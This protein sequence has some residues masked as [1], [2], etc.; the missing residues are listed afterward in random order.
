MIM[1][2]MID[3]CIKINLFRVISII[4][5]NKTK[6]ITVVVLTII[7][8]KLTFKCVYFNC[9]LKMYN[10]SLNSVVTKVKLLTNIDAYR[11]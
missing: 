4:S 1:S 11:V 7:I 6:S 5:H 3:F 10:N 9:D 2:Q 8:L